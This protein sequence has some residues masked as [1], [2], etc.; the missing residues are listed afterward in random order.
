MNLVTAL[1]KVMNSVVLSINSLSCS[2]NIFSFTGLMRILAI[3]IYSFYTLRKI[4]TVDMVLSYPLT[5][6]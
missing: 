6:M 3:E 4:C 5:K 1:L 2:R